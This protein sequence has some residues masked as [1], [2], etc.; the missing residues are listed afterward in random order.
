MVTFLVRNSFYIKEGQR[1]ESIFALNLLA[2]PYS[3]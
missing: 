2:S 1:S 3:Q